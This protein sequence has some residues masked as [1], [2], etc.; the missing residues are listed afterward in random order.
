MSANYSIRMK[1]TGN[2]DD[3]AFY[4]ENYLNESTTQSELKC[5]NN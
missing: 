5:L 3:T 1:Q 2:G 4:V